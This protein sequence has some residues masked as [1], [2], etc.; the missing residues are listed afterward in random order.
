MK[1]SV[2]YVV[3]LLLAVNVFTL[4]IN[5]YPIVMSGLATSEARVSLYVQGTE[6]KTTTPI[7]SEGGTTG[8]Y[9]TKEAGAPEAAAVPGQITAEEETPFIKGDEME[10]NI[11]SVL[12]AFLLLALIIWI[13]LRK[14]KKK[15]KRRKRR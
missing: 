12:G 15:A 6:E 2:A 3:I 5:V 4:A 13:I 10:F 9:E 7:P 14:K 11:Y 1:K 8:V